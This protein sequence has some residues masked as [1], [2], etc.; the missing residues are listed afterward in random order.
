MARRDLDNLY[1]RCTC[2]RRAWPKCRHAWW[3][4]F[5]WRGTSYRFSLQPFVATKDG[6]CT[7]TEAANLRDECQRRIRA[8]ELTPNG[9]FVKPPEAVADDVAPP[10][11][12]QLLEQYERDHV[13]APGRRTSAL[14]AQRAVLKQIKALTCDGASGQPILLVRKLARDITAADLESVRAHHR[15]RHAEAQNA[16]QT[17]ATAETPFPPETVSRLAPLAR[18]ARRS[19]K[20][21]EVAMNRLLARLRHVFSWAIKRGLLDATPFRRHGVVTVS[22]TTAVEG[23]R[24]RR[25][26]G[27]E[28]ARL[29]AAAGPHLKLLIQGALATG[30]R[31][32]ELLA[33]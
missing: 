3:M 28:R 30:A 5:G 10:T 7:R 4:S 20:S 26:E 13:A 19:G 21:G 23:H 1:K 2:P 11:L 33:L 9:K 22:L 8:G 25:L 29:L 27:D 12:D 15:A 6:S 14:A 24:T 16:L 17:L 31:K 32:G 18:L